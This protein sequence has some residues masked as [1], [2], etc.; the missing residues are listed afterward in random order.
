MTSV[1]FCESLGLAFLCFC[2]PT[3]PDDP[4]VIAVWDGENWVDEIGESFVGSAECI[5]C[6]KRF[7]LPEPKE[8]KRDSQS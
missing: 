2:N 5:G 1:E 3:D 4:H 6:S 7:E 8:R